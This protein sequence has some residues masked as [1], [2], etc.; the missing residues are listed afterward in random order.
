MNHAFLDGDGKLDTLHARQTELAGKLLLRDAFAVPL[1]TLAGIHIEDDGA[2][3]SATVVLLHA[4]TLAPLERQQATTQSHLPNRTDV[5]GF[6]ALPAVLDALAALSQRPDLAFVAGHGIDH[7]RRFGSA[8]LIGLAADLPSIGVS[9]SILT[10]TTRLVLHEMRGAFTPLR[11][12][13]QQIG[14]L[15]RSKVGA[16]PLVVAPGHRVSMASAPGLV[17]RQVAQHALPEP[18]RR[19]TPA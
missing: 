7:P 18:L 8:C 10:G 3:V 4:D 16:A 2:S 9:P 1:R 13:T 6:R 12:G 19:V 11:D 15:L 14:W 5:L 17:M